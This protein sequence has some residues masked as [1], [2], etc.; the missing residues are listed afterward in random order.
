[1]GCAAPHP[2]HWQ[3]LRRRAPE[4]LCAL[5]GVRVTGSGAGLLV[6]MSFLNATYEV[7]PR[8]ERIRE[9]SPFPGRLVEEDFQILLL[10]YLEAPQGPTPRGEEIS[11][12]ELPGGVTFFQGPHSL[13]V[14]SVLERFGS[15]PDGF[16]ASG[17]AL[18]ARPR[19]GLGD[20]ALLFEPFPGVP[21]T[22]VLWVADEEFPASLSVLL[23]RGIA[24]RFTLDMV[25]ILVHV[26]A[27]RLVGA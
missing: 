3:S 2:L 10:A 18:G 17:K 7:D 14:G 21:V 1:M 13:Q 12:K 19:P 6:E 11:E 26:L 5:R 24:E 9:R 27:R 23:D 4:E 15:D 20:R 22:L 8:G 16:E 25:Y